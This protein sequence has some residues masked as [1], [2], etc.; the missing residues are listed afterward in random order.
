[1][2]LEI[3]NLGGLEEAPHWPSGGEVKAVAG[4]EDRLFV[5]P[6]GRATLTIRVAPARSYVASHSRWP[7][8]VNFHGGSGIVGD[9]EIHDALSGR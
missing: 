7:M 3:V 8:C 9:V 4:I 2:L 5:A 1:M 6:H